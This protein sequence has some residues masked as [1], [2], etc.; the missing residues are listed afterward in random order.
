MPRPLT[1]NQFQL[2]KVLDGM[3]DMA[4]LNSIYREIN[5]GRSKSFDLGA[6]H[7]VLNRL[8]KSGVLETYEIT[9]DDFDDGRTRTLVVYKVTP[10]GRLAYDATRT[11][12]QEAGAEP[13]VA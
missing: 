11:I 13:N 6:I 8:R 3:G 1:L 10:K 9:T 2:V 12:I 5:K 4:Y 7:V